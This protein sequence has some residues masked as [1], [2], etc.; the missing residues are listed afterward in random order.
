MAKNEIVPQIN[1]VT[2]IS[3]GAEIKGV[4]NSSCDIRIDG[5][6]EGKLITTGKLVVGDNAKFI[7]EVMCRNCDI[8]GT[9]EGTLVVSELFGLK[10]SACITGDVSCRRLIIE[11][12]ASFDGTC[13]MITES[14]RAAIEAK[15]KL[16]EPK[17]SKTETTKAETAKTETT[18][19]E[20]KPKLKPKAE[21]KPVTKPEAKPDIEAKQ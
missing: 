7:G 17:A 2:R 8:W 20:T 3:A 15:V 13:T 11:E 6:F 21:T 5:V 19:T 14:N 4:M 10:K 12:G 1:E 9:I 16:T 18:K